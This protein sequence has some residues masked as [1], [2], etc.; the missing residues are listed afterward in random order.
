MG[1][2]LWDYDEKERLIGEHFAARV[3]YRVRSSTSMKVPLSLPPSTFDPL[4][5]PP[6]PAAHSRPLAY[7]RAQRFWARF[8]FTDFHDGWDHQS[9][10]LGTI[11]GI[12]AMG[13]MCQVTWDEEGELKESTDWYATGYCELP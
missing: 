7:P 10:R 11:V 2:I 3:G 4:W 6:L 9:D 1:G 8:N 5:N 13:D 12:T